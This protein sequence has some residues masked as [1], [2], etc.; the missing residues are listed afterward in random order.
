MPSFFQLNAKHLKPVRLLVIKMAIDYDLIDHWLA[1]FTIRAAYIRYPA[2]LP[3]FLYLDD[4]ISQF[5]PRFDIAVRLNSVLQR[6]AAIDDRFDLARLDQ[7]L[8]EG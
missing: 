3:L 5:A 4:D 2:P 8:D 6:I 1:C 7:P